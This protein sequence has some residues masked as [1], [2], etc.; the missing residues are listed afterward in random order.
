MRK[1][2]KRDAAAVPAAATTSIARAVII[3]ILWSLV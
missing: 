3:K 2:G 1:R